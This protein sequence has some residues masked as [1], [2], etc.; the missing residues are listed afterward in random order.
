M[1][2]DGDRKRYDG[3]RVCGKMRKIR[4]KSGVIRILCT[5]PRDSRTDCDSARQRP[6]WP[7]RDRLRL[8]SRTPTIGRTAYISPSSA[9][10]SHTTRAPYIRIW[11][12]NGAPPYHFDLYPHAAFTYITYCTTPFLSSWIFIFTSLSSS[13]RSVTIT[14]CVPSLFQCSFLPLHARARALRVYLPIV[15]LC[16]SKMATCSRQKRGS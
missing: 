15:L 6:A 14:R 16:I 1:V 12:A 5:S 10:Y 3:E 9:I 13:P 8:G 7:A 11:V 4:R 2:T